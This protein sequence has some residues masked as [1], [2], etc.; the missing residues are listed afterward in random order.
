ML[1]RD[2]QVFD[3]EKIVQLPVGDETD[4]LAFVAD[5]GE[6]ESRIVE[7]QF[8]LEERTPLVFGEGRVVDHPKAAELG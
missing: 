1:R 3:E 2:G 4:G 8:V 5:G 7:E 6:V